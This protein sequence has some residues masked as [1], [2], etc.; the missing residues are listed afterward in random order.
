VK[1]EPLPSEATLALLSQYARNEI[2][3]LSED[4][5]QSRLKTQDRKIE[6][7]TRQLELLKQIDQGPRAPLISPM[8]PPAAIAPE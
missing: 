8:H 1:A 6:Q 5:L 3:I 7:L 4:R 2:Q